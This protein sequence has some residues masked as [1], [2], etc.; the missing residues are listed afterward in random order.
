MI[1]YSILIN[2]ILY[3]NQLTADRW[4]ISCPAMS[5]AVAFCGP[6][7]EPATWQRSHGGFG[8]GMFWPFLGYFLACFMEQFMGENIRRV[9]Y[10]EKSY[11]MGNEL[12]HIPQV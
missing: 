10:G 9:I 5:G 7:N 11:F 8:S 3:D 4:Y 1:I 12:V 2:K 6:G